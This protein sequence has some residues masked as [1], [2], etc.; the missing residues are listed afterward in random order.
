MQVGTGG[1]NRARRGT[2]EVAKGRHRS[3][4]GRFGRSP[5]TPNDAAIAQWNGDSGQLW[6][7]SADQR[8]LALVQV[9]DVLLD[10]ASPDAGEA[11]L[12]IG[13]GCGAT[14]L[15]AAEA[16]GPDGHALG[17]DISGPMLDVARQR[18]AQRGLPNATFQQADAQTQPL[19]T[20][21]HDLAISRFGTMFFDDAGAAFTNIARSLRP[22][23]RLCIA[24]WQPM[25]ANEWLGLAST[26]LGRFGP[27]P[28]APPASGMFAQSEPARV[29]ALLRGAG[30]TDVHV[31]ARDV[32]VRLGDDI[33]AATDYL[34]ELGLSR[35]ALEA[36]AP[37]DR[38]RAIDAIR[39][40]LE[41]HVR[42]DGVHLGGAI[43][44]T[45][46]SIG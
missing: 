12:D 24:T 37:V 40:A 15:A 10:A 28:A 20:A 5:M 23:G 36:M 45:T 32:A 21:A 18:A 19:P 26:E 35:A 44:V 4:D 41:P 11:V 39:T 9:L 16:V 29:E 31:D 6:A 38:P 27:P 3:S 46:A 14:T 43:L 2:K 33:G 13:C 42:A 22:G 1:S 8:D 17:V 34:T 25:A 30:F 7:R